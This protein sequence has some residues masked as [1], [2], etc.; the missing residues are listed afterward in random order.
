MRYNYKRRPTRVVSIGG[1]GVGGDNPVRLQSMTNTPSLDV[2]ATAAQAIRIVDAGGEIVR[3]TTQGVREAEALGQVRELL[4]KQGRHVPL[5]ADVHFNPRA[6]MTAA[7]TAHKVRINPGNFADQPRVVDD[8][9]ELSTK[10]YIAALDRVEAEFV[11]LLDLCRQRGTA[12]RLGVNHGSLSHRVMMR[13]G[14][15]PLG[16]T[17]SVMEYLDIARRHD[18]HDI[19]ISV[20]ASNPVV[21]ADTVRM[22]AVRMEAEGMDYPLHLGVT[23]A[24]ACSAA[25]TLSSC[26]SA[27]R[28]LTPR[29][30]A[31]WRVPT[32]APCSSMDMAPAYGSTPKESIGRSS[33]TFPWRFSRPRACASPVPSTSP[34]PAAAAPS[35]TWRAPCAACSRPPRE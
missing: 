5:V 10:E 23:E 30:P 22:L 33:P 13:Y 28:A 1:V 14:D 17:E 20:K 19:V 31:S 7:V 9:R 34:A 2:D 12:L 25:A 29:P 26:T 15:T 6:A 3:V 27:I 4:E 11:P 16:M 8:G 35:L 24:C 32:S 21:M 18:F